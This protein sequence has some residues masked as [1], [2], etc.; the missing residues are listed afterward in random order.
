MR[1]E[2]ELPCSTA[3]RSSAVSGAASRVVSA[4]V[5]VVVVEEWWFVRDGGPTFFDSFNWVT[6][7]VRLSTV[8]D[9]PMRGATLDLPFTASL[10]TTIPTIR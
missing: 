9:V 8:S 10:P 4:I 1:E 7:W 2:E 3:V 5:G 6:W